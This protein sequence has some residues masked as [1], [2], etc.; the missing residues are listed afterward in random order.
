MRRTIPFPAGPMHMRARIEGGVV[1][2]PYADC[3]PLDG[4]STSAFLMER[5]LRHGSKTAVLCGHEKLT[6]LELRERLQLCAV[7][8]QREGVGPGARV[9]AHVGNSISSLVAVCSI[10]LTGA[11]LVTSDCMLPEDEILDRAA[12]AAA[13]HV[14]T[15]AGH[16][17]QFSRVEGRCKIKGFLL[18][19]ESGPGFRNASSLYSGD[20]LSSQD[21]D[22]TTAGCCRFVNWSTGT[23]GAAKCVEIPESRFLRQIVCRETVEM[24]SSDD[25][26]LGD[27][28]ISCFF[29][30]SMWFLALCVGSTI[31]I[32]KTCQAVAMDTLHIIENFKS[33]AMASFPSRLQ[34]ILNAVKTPRNSCSAFRRSLRKLL[35]VGASMPPALVE[36]LTRTF[37]LDE[38][39]SCYG[40]TEAGG[41]IAVPPKETT[42]GVTVGFPVSAIK[43]KIVDAV[44]GKALGPMECGE[45]LLNTP[46]AGSAPRA[47]FDVTEDFTDG[48]V[49]LRT[50]D[51]G[52]YDQ[53]G[54]LFLC[55]R[56]NAAFNSQTRK[57][58]PSEIEL[59][60]LG[61]AAVKEVAVLGVPSA[62]HDEA[63]AAVVVPKNGYSADQLLAE[64][65]KVYV[66]D[67]TASYKHLR[68]G[69]YFADA[70]PESSL[71]KV[72]RAGL[73]D[74]LGTL[75][76][77]DGAECGTDECQ[78]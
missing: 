73:R 45:V 55:G 77:M 31:V 74:L 25:V 8:L 15:D 9:Y 16:A 7:K 2:S 44:H 33:V 76:R 14:L 13:T 27:S 42:Y 36:D 21:L 29:V 19:D 40:M 51:L 62:D 22:F 38:L 54:R 63:P 71:G 72:R 5:L 53:D 52:Y 78:Y 58:V 39:R 75:R 56:L 37:Q 11:T 3:P 30:F 12:R 59:C 4:T 61:H 6:Y 70:L 35:V 47:D 20:D 46:Y 10:P 18:L 48:Q 66:A 26:F 65:L 34:K 68:G 32:S 60:L 64:D 41:F 17:G 28:N 24:L 69:V 1:H 23:T 50:G 57:V 67:R 49:W 43:I